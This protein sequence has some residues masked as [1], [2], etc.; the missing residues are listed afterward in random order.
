MYYLLVFIFLHQI[1]YGSLLK[2][3][4][5]FVESFNSFYTPVEF[6]I[7]S[8]YIRTLL[9]SRFYKTFTLISIFIYFTF[10]IPLFFFSGTQENI[11]YIRAFSYSLI[12]IFS[13]F[14]YYEQIRHPKTFFV[15]MQKSFWIVSGFFLFAAG[16]FFIFLFD[17]FS[18]NVKGFFDQ[19]VYIHALL[20]IVRNFLFSAAILIKPETTTLNDEN[21]VL[22]A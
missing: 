7:T 19:Y 2:R 12:L 22:L 5:D 20:F 13:L 17:K 8:L 4:S 15:Y 16:T 9:L 11:S 10:W 1:I 14:Y 6:L 18:D 21:S 3:G